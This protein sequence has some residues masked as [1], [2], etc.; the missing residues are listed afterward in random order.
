MTSS[1]EAVARSAEV[2]T[3]AA[4]GTSHNVSELAEAV[5]QVTGIAA[6]ADR[7]SREASE[8]A[9]TGD[10][11][12][13][14]TLDGMRNVSESMDRTASE[15]SNLGERSQQIGKILGVIEQIADQ[16][17]LLALNAAIEAAR[18][19]EAGRGFAV[20]ADEVRKLAES[21][22]EAANEIGSVVRQVQED[23]ATAVKTAKAGAAEAKAGIQLADK[24]G[25]VLRSIIQSVARSSDLMTEIAS[26]TARQSAVSA[27]A[28]RTVV[29]MNRATAQVTTA[30]RE[31]AA[32]SRRIR[33]AVETVNGVMSELAASTKEQEAG[34]RQVL[35]AVEGVKRIASGVETATREQA[36]GSRQIVAAAE[37]MSHKTQQVSHATAEQRRGGELV[38]QAM[39]NISK[40]ARENLATVEEMSRATANLA[41]QAEGLARLTA[42]FRS[43]QDGSEE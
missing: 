39:E 15:I 2:L 7:I 24:A 5:E 36:E 23:T 20:V 11:A 10:A 43:E 33:E 30:V 40:V 21:S 28:Q 42:A 37:S 29:D 1:I 6:E 4:A 14:T 41:E 27:E 19:G 32:G 13:A 18:A 31:Q 17:N 26:S 16:T 8:E 25:V 35:G 9:R 3:E 22:I 38:V 34:G 12:I